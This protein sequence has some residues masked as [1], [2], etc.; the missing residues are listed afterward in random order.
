M[1]SENDLVE[2]LSLIWGIPSVLDL[3]NACLVAR[4]T[5]FEA[6]ISE[7]WTWAFSFGV[8]MYTP[9]RR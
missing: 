8:P 1:K 6:W 7:F 3:Q 9:V 2:S 5:P 4:T